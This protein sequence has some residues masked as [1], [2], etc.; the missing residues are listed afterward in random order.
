MSAACAPATATKPAAVPR[1]RL[2]TIFISTSIV[3][4]GGIGLR[5]ALLTLE[6]S[7]NAPLSLP[8]SPLPPLSP[9]HR[10]DRKERHGDA[11]LRRRSTLAQ[12][13]P[14]ATTKRHFEQSETLFS[15]RCCSNITWISPPPGPHDTT[16]C[17]S[18]AWR[19]VS[20]RLWN[21]PASCYARETWNGA[22]QSSA[23]VTCRLSGHWLSAPIGLTEPPATLSHQTSAL[24]SLR[25]LLHIRGSSELNLPHASTSS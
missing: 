22:E 16:F 24:E 8:A 1:R 5:R 4:L 3:I 14:L 17:R 18:D 23:C 10:I 6:E 2:F 11:P 9:G 25:E 20:L 21:R 7:P 19:R 12:L 13:F 15:E